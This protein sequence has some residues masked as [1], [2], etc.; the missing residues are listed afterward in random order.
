MGAALHIGHVARGMF[1]LSVNGSALG[2]EDR[3]HAR[4]SISY[5]QRTVAHFFCMSGTLPPP[6]SGQG[7]DTVTRELLR[8]LYGLST[9]RFHGAVVIFVRNI[10]RHSQPQTNTTGNNKKENRKNKKY[11]GKK[12]VL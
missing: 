11:K 9:F 4:D 6:T 10:R 1:H 5:N 7:V 3:T 8:A 2:W 12:K